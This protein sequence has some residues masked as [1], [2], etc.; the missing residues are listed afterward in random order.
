MVGREGAGREGAG[1][2]GAVRRS[3]QG[4][5][6]QH[7]PEAFVDSGPQDTGTGIVVIDDGG[8]YALSETGQRLRTAMRPLLDWSHEW[9]ASLEGHV[10]S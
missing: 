5:M 10:E 3:E 8:N 9:A 2:E 4:A 7:S 6:A 1:R